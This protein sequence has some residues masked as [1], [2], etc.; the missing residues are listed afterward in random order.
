[1]KNYYDDY[2]DSA[3]RP[4]RRRRRGGAWVIVSMMVIAFIVGGMTMVALNGGVG[5]EPPGLF[6]E[7]TAT[8]SPWV[9][10]N[11]APTPVPSAQPELGG[12]QAW[13]FST[14]DQI[15]DIAEQVGPTVVGVTNNTLVNY[16]NRGKVEEATSSGSGVIISEDGYILTNHHVIKD[17]S[18]ITVTMAGG[19]DYR[20]KVI[21]SDERAD[22]AVLKIEEAGLKPAVLGNSEKVRTGQLAIAIG[23]PLGQELAGTVTVGF[24][25]AAQRVIA[26]DNTGRTMTM[27]QTDAA[28]NPGN[29]GG[30][31]V[32][33]K[34]ELIGIITMKSTSAGYDDYGNPISAEGIGFC[35]PTNTAVSIA[36]EL[37]KNGY[38]SRPW[39]GIGG[40][41][42]IDEYT[43]QQSGLPEGVWV[44][45]VY[46]QTPATRGGFL[47]DDIIVKVDGQNI[48][49]YAAL[50]SLISSKKVGD[51]LYITVYRD[52]ERR[53]VELNI[54][55]DEYHNYDQSLLEQPDQSEDNNTLWPWWPGEED[56]P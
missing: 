12:K 27:L 30:A 4:P 33:G 10:E 46:P 31:L 49:T 8:Q 32:N 25:S 44:R 13:L 34:G 16:R 24:V 43:A 51:Q 7:P 3:Y 11:P 9:N 55:L 48:K 50:N 41:T 35:I 28:I 26:V 47:P 36:Q 14:E 18:S 40:L 15:A 53:E 38:V 45:E 52:S 23:N 39:I 54:T 56:M 29:S 2:Y 1:M 19:K 6:P 17:A 20:A 21:G 22:L 5:L 37:I 42:E